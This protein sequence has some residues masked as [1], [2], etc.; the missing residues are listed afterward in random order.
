MV[1]ANNRIALA[2][3]LSVGQWHD[4]PLDRL[5]LDDGRLDGLVKQDGIFMAMDRGYEDDVTRKLVS[6]KGFIPVVP[7]KSNRTN[8]WEYDKER[9][10]RRN[11]VERLFRRFKR[12]R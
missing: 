11:E 10:K 5:L 6:E 3:Q 1:A 12:F 4:A 2:F 7:S 8:P 9:Y